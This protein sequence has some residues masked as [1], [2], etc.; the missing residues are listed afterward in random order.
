MNRCSALGLALLL[1]ALC[2]TTPTWW[3]A[4]RA[5]DGDALTITTWGGAYEAGQRAA[6][7]EPFERAAGIEIRLKAYDGGVEPLRRQ[8]E[9]GDRGWD[10]LDMTEPDARAACDQGLLEPFDPN[11]LGPAPDGSAA[12]VDFLDGAVLDCGVV[13]LVYATVLAYDDRAFPGEKPQRISDLF[14]IERFPGK[15]ALRRQPIALLEWALLSYGVPVS[16]LRDLLSTERGLTLAFRKLDQIREHIVWWDSGSEPPALLASG[17]VVMASGF[18]GRFFN[19]RVNEEIPI[20]VIWD[21]QFLDSSVWVIA[22]GTAQRAL[23]ERFIGFATRA[24]TMAALAQLIPY[25]PMRHSALRR[26]GLHAGSNVPILQHMPT[27]PANLRRAIRAD[28]RWYAGTEAVRQ[29]WFK[30]WLERGP[31]G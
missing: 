9:T 14:D 7:F 17:E 11:L 26:I 8:I 6:Y 29:R 27:S 24:E 12:S 2:A 28:S 3:E 13:H 10:V 21:G 5:E 31:E 4:A 19:A 22:K 1:C 23:A 15:R 30:A 18:N 25:G 20:T 16:Q